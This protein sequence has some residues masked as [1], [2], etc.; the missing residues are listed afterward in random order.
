MHIGKVKFRLARWL[1]ALAAALLLS[2]SLTAC[3]SPAP[4]Y[5]GL[6]V[7]AT[8]TGRCSNGIKVELVGVQE[9]WLRPGYEHGENENTYGVGNYWTWVK[10]GKQSGVE[11]M[12]LY[13]LDKNPTGKTIIIRAYCMR[14]GGADP[15]VSKRAFAATGLM[16]GNRVDA[17][18]EVFDSGGNPPCTVTSPGVT[19]KRSH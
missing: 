3:P 16:A 9:G 19:I 11:W 8:N 1:A 14:T 6:F 4:G 17:T 10:P 2:L 12:T 13:G 15:G 18:F 7:D 5:L